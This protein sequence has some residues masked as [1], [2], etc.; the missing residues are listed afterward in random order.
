MGLNMAQVLGNQSPKVCVD[1]HPATNLRIT[2]IPLRRAACRAMCG[3]K[4][5]DLESFS[6]CWVSALC[7]INE[8]IHIGP[9]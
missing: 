3:G 8:T 9:P 1:F 6:M 2:V 4:D 5:S 7:G